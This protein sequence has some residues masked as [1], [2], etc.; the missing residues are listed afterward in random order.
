MQG[1]EKNSESNIKKCYSQAKLSNYKGIPKRLSQK[2]TP[3][4]CMLLLDTTELR[5]HLAMAIYHVL[6]EEVNL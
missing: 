2:Y 4:Q 3:C 6:F 1:G 5:W